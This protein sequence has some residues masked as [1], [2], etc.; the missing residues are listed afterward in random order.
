MVCP[1][2]ISADPS[3][4]AAV[5][6]DFVIALLF[7]P[8]VEQHIGAPVAMMPSTTPMALDCYG[9]GLATAASQYQPFN[10]AQACKG[11]D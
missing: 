11:T 1:I 5:I 7:Q 9:W 3:A 10:M 8:G 2:R 4:H 6:A